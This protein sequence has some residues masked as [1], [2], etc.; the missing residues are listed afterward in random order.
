MLSLRSAAW[1]PGLTCQPYKHSTPALMSSRFYHHLLIVLVSLVSTQALHAATRT[2][3]FAW[4]ASPS[5]EVVGY[6]IFWGTGSH[7]YQNVRDV[8]NVLTTSLAL[9]ET[10]YYVAVS[11][12]SMTANSWSSNEVIVPPL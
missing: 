11:A 3:K 9:S 5:A 12:Y 2:V 1:P 6:K 7:N 8:K 10:K 4:K